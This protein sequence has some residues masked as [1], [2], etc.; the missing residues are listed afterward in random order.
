MGIIEH[1]LNRRSA[2]GVAVAAGAAVALPITVDARPPRP[3]WKHQRN[4]GT[5]GAGLGELDDPMGIALSSDGY[6]ALVVDTINSRV[7]V[8]SKVNKTWVWQQ[9]FGS[10]G[11]LDDEFI[12]PQFVAL[13]PDG[14]TAYVA[15][16]GN[17]RVSI[18]GLGLGGWFHIENFGTIGDTDQEFGLPTGIGVSYDG[19]VL[20]ADFALNRVAVWQLVAGVWTCTQ[21]FGTP[22][23]NGNI[24]GDSPWNIVGPVGIGMTPD[25]RSAFV[26]LEGESRISI[27]NSIN[28]RWI[29]DT[30][31]GHPLGSNPGQTFYPTDVAV[32]RNGQTCLVSDSDNHRVSVWRKKH[33]GWQHVGMFGLPGAGPEKFGITTGISVTNNGRDVLVVDQTNSRVSQWKATRWGRRMGRKDSY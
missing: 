22:S 9:N 25:A 30:S 26:C 15:D 11:S 10:F 16:T 20:V 12:F 7:S 4:F 24:P 5:D 31:L 21:T 2:L 14:L 8:W 17:G 28:G 1:R 23:Y 27:W 19:S 6:M 32:G 18:W 29:Y 33:G 3:E 13:S